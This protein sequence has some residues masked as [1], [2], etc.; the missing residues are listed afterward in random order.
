MVG[1]TLQ[2]LLL[3]TIISTS[4]S[5]YYHQTTPIVIALELSQSM[6]RFY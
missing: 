6:R 4:L 1:N 2:L 3:L 5:L